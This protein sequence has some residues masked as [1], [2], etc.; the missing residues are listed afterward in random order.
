MRRLGRHL[1]EWV[2]IHGL[3]RGLPYPWNSHLIH[4][5]E[6]GVRALV[7]PLPMSDEDLAVIEEIGAPTHILITNNYHERSAE[8][9]R[10][11]WNCQTLLHEN[12]VG[13]AECEVDGTLKSGQVLWGS[14]EVVRVPDVRFAEEVSFLLKEDR[15][16]IVGDLVS[17]PRQDVGIPAGTVGIRAPELYVDLTNARAALRSLLALPFDR[18]CF[19]HGSP[20]DSGAKDVL[21]EFVNDDGTWLELE[22][23]RSA[24]QDRS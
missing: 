16:L 15:T 4:L 7:D 11:R 17:G 12:Q 6:A 5:E 18:L 10:A 20:L 14:V 13:E 2:E 19:A 24:K 8:E 1:Y 3:A 23:A 21:T 22:G 9:F